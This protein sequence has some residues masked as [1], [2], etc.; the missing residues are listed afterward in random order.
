[1]K[2]SPTA[3]AS[4]AVAKVEEIFKKFNPEQPFEYSFVDVEYGRKFGNEERVGKLATAFSALAIIISCLG[5]FG[6][7][8]FVA[9]QRTKEI[10][11]RKVLGASMVNVWQLISKEFVW[12]V[13]VSCVMA[14]PLGYFL[15]KSWLNGFTYR[16]EISWWIFAL[17]F[18]G[19][20]V[21][22]LLTVST[23]AIKAA[24]S[25]PVKSLRS[26]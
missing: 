17:S 6:L 9:E 5:I 18:L 10:G 26:E 11:I 12:L 22:T 15:L 7:A 2:I 23:Q 16:T 3:S 21:I 8:A 24:M 19:A 14:A 20:L 1:L 25:N 4:E 13:M